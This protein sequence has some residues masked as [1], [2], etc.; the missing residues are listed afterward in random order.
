MKL[1]KMFQDPFQTKNFHE[2]LQH[3]A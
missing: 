2:I 3:R 1:K